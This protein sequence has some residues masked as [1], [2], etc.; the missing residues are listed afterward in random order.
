MG[1]AHQQSIGAMDGHTAGE[2]VVDGQLAHRSGGVVAALLIHVSIHVEV[3]G[4]VSHGLLAHVLQLQPRYMHRSK[5]VLHLNVPKEE[6]TDRALYLRVPNTR[7][8]V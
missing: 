7:L 4:I 2:R 6:V 3:D 1:K 8:T 5:A